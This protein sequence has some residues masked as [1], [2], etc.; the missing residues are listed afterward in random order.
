[1]HTYMLVDARAKHNFGKERFSGVPSR[2]LK[3]GRQKIQNVSIHWK[4]VNLM[5]AAIACLN[6]GKVCRLPLV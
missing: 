5:P 1:M 3:K 2:G 6:T 4:M